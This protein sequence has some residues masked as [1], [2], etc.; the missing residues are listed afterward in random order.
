MPANLPY[1]PPHS[2]RSPKKSTQLAGPAP[3]RAGPLKRQN[4]L[5][6]R[7][8][9]LQFHVFSPLAPDTHGASEHENPDRPAEQ[10]RGEKENIL[11]ILPTFSNGRPA[12]TEKK[13]RN[14]LT[15]R[16]VSNHIKPHIPD[17]HTD[18]SNPL[19]MSLGRA[20]HSKNQHASTNIIV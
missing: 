17:M 11:C 4:A 14:N 2:P 12:K 16:N 15:C 19:W 10:L 9:A 5:P 1:P 13:A 8:Q 3:K 7:G 6:E 18:G 20:A